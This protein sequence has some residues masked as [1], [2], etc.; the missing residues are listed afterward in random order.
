[1][2]SLRHVNYRNLQGCGLS[3]MIGLYR[4][5]G[6][7]EL[8]LGLVGEVRDLEPRTKGQLWGWSG[9]ASLKNPRPP[10]P[11]P[12]PPSRALQVSDVGFPA[13]SAGLRRATAL[14]PH[15]P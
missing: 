4:V 12:P 3:N 14:K 11:A 15:K 6:G 8:K 10:P 9:R 7:V 1:M 13:F 2:R 5:Y